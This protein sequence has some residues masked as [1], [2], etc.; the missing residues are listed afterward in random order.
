MAGEMIGEEVGAADGDGG[1]VGGRGAWGDT[2]WEGYRKVG[3]K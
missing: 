1:G 3:G 2:D